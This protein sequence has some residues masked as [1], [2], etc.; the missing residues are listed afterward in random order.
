MVLNIDMKY[1]WST[2]SAY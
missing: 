1:F 2:K